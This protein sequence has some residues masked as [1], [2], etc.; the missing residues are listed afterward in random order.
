MSYT[1][2]FYACSSKEIASLVKSDA[3]LVERTLDRVK[4]STQATK[5]DIVELQRILKSGLRGEW[6]TSDNSDA[7]LAF[8][9]M[10]ETIA[11]PIPVEQLFEFRKW[12]YWESTGLIRSLI[13]QEP[14]FSVPKSSVCPPTV[15]FLP[16][17]RME[18]V[19]NERFDTQEHDSQVLRE[20]LNSIIESVLTDGLDLIAVVLN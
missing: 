11:E 6:P 3:F 2:Y 16:N 19:V 5:D 7:F 9:W 13:D 12:Q 18:S 17:S 20:E 4:E 1:I 14:P 15:Y 10:L 8:H